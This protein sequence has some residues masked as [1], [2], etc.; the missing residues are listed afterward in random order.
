LSID[1]FGVNIGF[2]A[3]DQKLILILVSAHWSPVRATKMSAFLSLTTVVLRMAIPL[4][5][6]LV[7]TLLPLRSNDIVDS[8]PFLLHSFQ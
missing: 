8:N 6:V 2:R 1:I 4:F 5:L 3:G 7:T